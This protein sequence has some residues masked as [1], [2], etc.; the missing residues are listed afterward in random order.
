MKASPQRVK[1]TGPGTRERGRVLIISEE[2]ESAIVEPL[3]AAGFELVGVCAGAAAPV[4]LRKTRPQ[5]VIA[6]SV[7]LKGIT[8][9]ELARMLSQTQ[10]GV[11]LLLVGAAP[12]TF[13]RRWTALSEGAVDYF[14][15]PA[16]LELLVLKAAQMLAVR[17]TIDKLRSEADLDHLTGLA[18]RRRFRVALTREVERWRRYGV[19]CALLLLDID[20]MKAINDRFGHP[21]GDLVIRHVA[22][23]LS[24]VSRDNDTAARL[25][26][27]EFAL[28][29][30]SISPEKAAAAAERLRRV[31]AERTVTD[32]GNIT[33]SIGVAACPAHANSERALYAASDGALYVAKNEGRNRVA[34]APLLQ[35]KLPGV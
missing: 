31:L 13:G 26:G 14:Q 34:I 24:E 7:T 4:S 5:I 10:D 17:Q 35:E 25:G 8:T 3:T 6:N 32:V 20:H 23:T 1:S 29:L 2:S 15:V 22:N 21:S 27:E 16:E 19:P 18:N 33:V 28:L 11:P 9:G 12:S 30:A